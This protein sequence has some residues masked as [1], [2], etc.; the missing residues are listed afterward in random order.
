MPC[1]NSAV[2]NLLHLSAPE[3]RNTFW[4]IRLAEWLDDKHREPS[5][6]SYFIHI[7]DSPDAR[8]VKAY[9]YYPCPFC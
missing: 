4:N 8:H 3:S 6:I 1:R 2:Y 7:Y 9:E 5:L